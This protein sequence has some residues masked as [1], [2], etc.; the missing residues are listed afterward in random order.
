MFWLWLGWVWTERVEGLVVH[1][2]V[3]GSTVCANRS[4]LNDVAV[5]S[6]RFDVPRDGRIVGDVRGINASFAGEARGV[7]KRSS[8]AAVVGIFIR[9]KFAEAGETVPL[10]V[11]ISGR[12]CVEEV[13]VG[14]GCIFEVEKRKTVDIGG[15]HVANG[16]GV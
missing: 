10:L 2:S 3:A 16:V 6:E 9:E 13:T 5:Y 14:C 7:G 12:P 8:K 15:F 4:L 1:N 11:V